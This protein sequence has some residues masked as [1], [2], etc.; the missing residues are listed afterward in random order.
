MS[1]SSSITLGEQPVGTHVETECE[2]N[3]HGGFKICKSCSNRIIECTQKALCR[4]SFMSQPSKDKTHDI[5]WPMTS[6]VEV[7]CCESARPNGSNYSSCVFFMKSFNALSLTIFFRRVTMKVY[8]CGIWALFGSYRFLRRL[9]TYYL[10]TLNVFYAGC[11]TS[12]NTD[13]NL[14]GF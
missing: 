5:I 6:L 1:W 4:K 2:M 7:H 12:D 9:S 11:Q 13:C 10:L 14:C 3:M 8:W